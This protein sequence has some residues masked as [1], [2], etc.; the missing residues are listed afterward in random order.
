MQTK[1]IAVSLVCFVALFSACTSE[2][3]GLHATEGQTLRV[4]VGQELDITL[5]SWGTSYYLSPPHVGSPTVIR[6]VGDTTICPC[7]PGGAGEMFRFKGEMLGRS[8]VVFQSS[9]Y[10]PNV[11][12]TVI[13]H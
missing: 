1:S 7:S 2:P 6:F 13:V 12:D 9:G 8:I 10:L 5:D 11:R 3:F 4:P